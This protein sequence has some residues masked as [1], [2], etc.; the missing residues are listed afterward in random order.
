MNLL[1][2]TDASLAMGTGHVMRCLALAQAWQDAGGGAVFGMAQTTAGVQARLAAEPYALSLFSGAPGTESDSIQTISLAQERGVDW[3]VVDGYQFAADYQRG[4]KAAG[5][6]VLFLDDYAHAA[7][8]SADLV[9]NQNAYA[10]EKMYDAREP[11]TRLLLGTDYCLLR[12][13]FA[14]WRD[15]K[16]KTVPA[17]N[18]VLVTMGGS[19]PENF[20]SVVIGALRRLP[21][22]ETTVVVGG[23]NPHFQSLQALTSQSGSR[24]QLLNNVVNMPELMARADAAIAGAGTTCWEMC[25]L[26]LPMLL[27]DLAENQK[28]IAVTLNDLG[29][30]IH[31]GTARNV[32]ES[33]IAER[34]VNLLASDAERA[35]LSDRCGKLV[36]GRGAERVLTELARG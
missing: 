31:L 8:Y 24:M 3:I 13:E 15:W 14:P 25:L 22:V 30:A 32:M 17:G 35:G 36:D 21:H 12:R 1:F 6:K 27:V 19:D 7:P 26:R 20:T 16:R 11:Y 2:R 9:L 33:E 28:P 4:L 23:S 10:G 5:F 18:K 29:A 34:V